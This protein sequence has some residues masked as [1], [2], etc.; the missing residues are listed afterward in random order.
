MKHPVPKQKKS[1]IRSKQQY[2]AFARRVKTQLAGMTNLTA[3]PQCREMKLQHH[4]C[5]T[6]GTYNGRQVIKMDQPKR[7]TVRTVKA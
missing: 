3:C 2:G 7:R 4:A 5:P 1:V 6:C